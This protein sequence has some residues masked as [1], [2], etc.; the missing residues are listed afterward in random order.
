MSRR[1]LGWVP[2]ALVLTVTGLVMLPVFWNGF[3]FDDLRVF[4]ASDRIH[5]L[6]NIPSFFL[7]N[8]LYVTDQATPTGVDTYRPLTLTTFA[9]DAAL[10][11]R[12]PL[13]Y[14]I[15]NLFLHLLCVGLVY[16]TAKRLM[17]EENQRYAWLAAAWFALS[18]WIG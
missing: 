3:V 7:H 9:L 12:S 10:T 5:E 2:L 11:G 1:D 15:T 8:T 17:A 4:L 13:G 14:H 6:A 16:A 18:P